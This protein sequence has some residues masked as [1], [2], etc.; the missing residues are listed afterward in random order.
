MYLCKSF[1]SKK[2]IMYEKVEVINDLQ[3][4]VYK[5]L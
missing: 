5:N 4:K 1:K 2:I 3:M